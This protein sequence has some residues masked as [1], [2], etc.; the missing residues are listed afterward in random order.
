MLLLSTSSLKGYGINRICDILKKSNYD[1]LDLYMDKEEYDLW[2]IEYM[3]KVKDL[4][5]IEILSITSPGEGLNKTK[6]NL[7]F[8]LAKALNVQVITFSPPRIED[9]DKTWFTKYIQEIKND[10]DFNVSIQNVE[11]KYIF[12]I[13]PKY[14]NM[15]LTDIKNITGYTSLDIANIDNDSSIDIIKAIKILGISLKN[16]F[17]SDKKGDTYGLLPGKEKSG[18][19]NLPIESFLMQL[20]SNSYNGFITL[21]VSPSELGVGNEE[22]ILK[23]LEKIKLYYNKYYLNFK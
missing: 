18:I 2:D 13:I 14:K 7:I 5:G 15:T 4:F 19:S 11:S 3:K 12:F 6:V 1:G 17:L 22:L 8:D 10:F 23:N 21:K 16:V 9:R 20:K